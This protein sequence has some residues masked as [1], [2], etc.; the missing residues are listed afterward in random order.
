MEVEQM[1][2][3]TISPA[4]IAFGTVE[5]DTLGHRLFV[6]GEEVGLER[7]AFAVLVLLARD[8]GRVLSRDEILD[9]VWGHSHVTPGV[10][11][12]VIAMLRHALGESG[13][14]S[15]YLHTVHGVGFRLDAD[16]RSA[17]SR[18]ELMV[19]RPL[20]ADALSF[21]PPR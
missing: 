5:I 3:E 1:A 18:E 11:S 4:W 7:K 12:R 21:V 19:E 2:V 16:V 14:E 17:A 10:L 13:D 8:P 9:E 15:R 6:D 20:P